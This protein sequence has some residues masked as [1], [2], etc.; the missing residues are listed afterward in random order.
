[1]VKQFTSPLSGLLHSEHKGTMV[2]WNTVQYKLNNAVSH[3]R[4]LQSSLSTSLL[5]AELLDEELWD[6]KQYSQLSL[7]KLL[8]HMC[9]HCH[10][11]ACNSLFQI[12]HTFC[13][14][15]LKN[16]S[17]FHFHWWLYCT[18]CSVRWYHV[19]L[20]ILYQMFCEVVPCWIDYTVPNVLWGGTV[21]NTYWGS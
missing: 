9:I 11:K 14:E 19:E 2:F 6:L 21:C 10:H 3:H 20:T 17:S 5:T 13:N 4:R 8:C 15:W 18:K 12:F 16:Q 1:M 7:Y